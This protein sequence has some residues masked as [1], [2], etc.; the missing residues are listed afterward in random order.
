MNSRGWLSV[1]VA[2]A[3]VVVVVGCDGGGGGGAGGGGGEGGQ[4]GSTGELPVPVQMGEALEVGGAGLDLVGAPVIGASDVGFAMAWQAE[5]LGYLDGKGA[6]VLPDGSATSGYFGAGEGAAAIVAAED[7]G[8]FGVA[9]VTSGG[10]FEGEGLAFNTVDGGGQTEG[11]KLTD[12]SYAPMSLDIVMTGGKWY[13]VT[14]LG[15]ELSGE[16]RIAE[17]LTSAQQSKLDPLP[18]SPLPIGQDAKCAEVKLAR[19]GGEVW[20]AYSAKVGEEDGVYLQRFLPGP[21]SGPVKVSAKVSGAEPEPERPYLFVDGDGLVVLY[22]DAGAERYAVRS[23]DAQGQATS[24]LAALATEED[25]HGAFDA[26]LVDG[27]VVI[28]TLAAGGVSVQSFELDGAEATA[29]L[30]VGPPGA[31]GAVRPAVAGYGDVA[32]IVHHGESPEDGNGRVYFT[33]VGGL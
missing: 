6:V 25:A 15:G 22:R 16:L 14:C 21:A 5:S 1:C 26:T 2:L 18:L 3:F 8:S 23:F 33:R 24:E 20:G 29:P 28:A 30:V 12:Y 27:R 32:G 17:D 19:L 4:G 10:P 13:L 11:F 9:R 31:Y 7:G